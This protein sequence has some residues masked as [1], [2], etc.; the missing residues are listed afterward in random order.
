MGTVPI[1]AQRKWD[2]PLPQRKRTPTQDGADRGSRAPDPDRVG[3]VPLR[4]TRW[5]PGSLRRCPAWPGAG[6]RAGCGV[7][8]RPVF[9]PLRSLAGSGRPPTA[10]PPLPGHNPHNRTF[11]TATAKENQKNPQNRP[12]P[13]CNGQRYSHFSL[14]DPPVVINTSVRRFQASYF[15]VRALPR[16][17]GLGTVVMLPA[18]S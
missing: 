2:C 13:A 8:P 17:H 15:T 16:L 1:F 12:P 10:R 7:A 6:E 14:S 11:P 18:A 9:A 5:G 3:G 4:A